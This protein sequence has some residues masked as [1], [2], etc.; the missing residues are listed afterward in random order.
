MTHFY[1]LTIIQEWAKTQKQKAF[2]FSKDIWDFHKQYNVY[3]SL[4]VYMLFCLSGFHGKMH[5]NTDAS[6]AFS[7]SGGTELW[8]SCL[9]KESFP[10]PI[11]T[12]YIIEW[13]VPFILKLDISG[14]NYRYSKKY[15]CKQR[16]KNTEWE[17]IYKWYM[18]MK[19]WEH[20]KF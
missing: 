11:N 13:N 19:I 1:N 16:E 12:F 2:F 20:W 9:H 10:R 3:Y 6:I 17:E 5:W 4:R 8:A 7:Q 14:I 18:Y 15:Q